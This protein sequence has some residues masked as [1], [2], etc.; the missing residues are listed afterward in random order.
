MAETLELARKLVKQE[1]AVAAA[2]DRVA[3][4]RQALE[5]AQRCAEQEQQ[6]LV[7]AREEYLVGGS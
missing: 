3:S 5:E 7:E 6:K 2:R 4:L 1:E